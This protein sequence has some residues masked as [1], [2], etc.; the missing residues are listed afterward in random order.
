[1]ANHRR[2]LDWSLLTLEQALAARIQKKSD[3]HA[4][5]PDAIHDLIEVDE[6]LRT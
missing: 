6:G 4:R 5:V 2:F 1:M 3:W